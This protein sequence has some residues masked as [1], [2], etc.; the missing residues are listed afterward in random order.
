LRLPAPVLQECVHTFQHITAVG[1]PDFQCGFSGKP[2]GQLVRCHHPGII[3]NEQYRCIEQFQEFP[4][5]EPV[6]GKDIMI[7][8]RADPVA[9]LIISAVMAD[10]VPAER[11]DCFHDEMLEKMLPVFRFKGGCFPQVPVTFLPHPD[12]L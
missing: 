1:V 4:G 12:P 10:N 5:I 11:T 8:G 6:P 3:I 9:D 7:A 2:P